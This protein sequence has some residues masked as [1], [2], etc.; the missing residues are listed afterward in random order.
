MFLPTLLKKT[1]RTPCN[2]AAFLAAG[3]WDKPK[4]PYINPSF[5]GDTFFYWEKIGVGINFGESPWDPD[6]II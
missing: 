2:R 3:V 5:C 4:R 6:K 1:I